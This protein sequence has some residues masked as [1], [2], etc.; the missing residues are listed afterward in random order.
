MSAGRPAFV[1][2]S[3]LSPDEIR[4]W[5]ARHGLDATHCRPLGAAL[6]PDHE[7]SFGYRSER[8]EAGA[9]DLRPRRGSVVQGALLAPTARGWE[10]LD[11]KEAVAAGAY[12]RRDVEVVLPDGG[13]RDATTYVVTEGRR[14]EHQSPDEGYLRTVEAGYARWGHD[15]APLRRA[16]A[17]EPGALHVDAVFV[18]G[19][20]LRGESNA[21]VLHGPGV[22]RVVDAALDGATLHETPNPYPVMRLGGVAAVIGELVEVHDVEAMLGPLDALEDFTGYGRSDRMYHR[23]L[24]RVRV[25]GGE[26]LAWTYVAGE[27]LAPGAPIASGSWRAH[28]AAR[29]R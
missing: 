2:G 5:L 26:R 29:A 10:A 4:G 3:N 12:E 19:T 14:R 11:A 21:H 22:R 7:L 6:L 24:V 27:T 1:Y 9:L 28:R 23:T 8:R 16:A 13:L 25:E 17:G 18:Y 20:L 15:P